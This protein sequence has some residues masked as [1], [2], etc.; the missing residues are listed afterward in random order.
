MSGKYNAH[1]P[2]AGYILNFAGVGNR[3][4]AVENVVEEFFNFITVEGKIFGIKVGYIITVTN[5]F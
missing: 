1:D 5:S 3:N 4:A 2:T